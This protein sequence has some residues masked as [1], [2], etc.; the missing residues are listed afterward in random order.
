MG[1]KSKHLSPLSDVDKHAV[2]ELI[3]ELATTQGWT[4][5]MIFRMLGKAIE[6][7][8]SEDLIDYAEFD[9]DLKTIKKLIESKEPINDWHMWGFFLWLRND[10]GKDLLDKQIGEQLKRKE[11]GIVS[12]RG[13]L[14]IWS[15]VN[16]GDMKSIQGDYKLYRPSHVAPMAKIIVSKLTVGKEDDY[17]H[18]ALSSKFND[19]YGTERT[20][21]FRGHIV[22][23]GQKLMAIMFDSVTNYEEPGVR[24][25]E[26][27]IKG[28]L[29]LHFDDVD[30]TA[31]D[32]AV[33]GL[34]GI[35]LMSVGAGPASAWP[36]I[37]RRA[38]EG[39]EPCELDAS[40]F[41]SL[42]EPIQDSLG[43][44]AVHWNPRFFPAPMAAPKP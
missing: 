6:A 21:F 1:R 14:G 28:N 37:A 10:Y 44:G 26:R 43:R 32:E 8:G 34:N 42:P 38:E 18:C 19:T 7:I 11:Q 5:T 2:A 3:S 41:A 31:N 17:F 9:P 22:P 35:V 33:R 36:I 4:P 39:F 30:Y 20:D 12:L 16:S 15:Q 23:H 27:S 24:F 29:V 13:L 40:D 25:S